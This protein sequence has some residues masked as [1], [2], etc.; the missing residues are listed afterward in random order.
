MPLFQPSRTIYHIG[1]HKTG[2]TSIQN[3]LRERFAPPKKTPK[4]A[5][6]VLYPDVG[7]PKDKAGNINANHNAL[8]YLYRKRNHPAVTEHSAA[9]ITTKIVSS[10]NELQPDTLVFS[11]EDAFFIGDRRPAH[12]ELAY[13]DAIIPYPKEFVALLRRPDLYV[14]SWQKQL[15]WF[16]TK[17]NPLHSSIRIDRLLSTCLLDY[18]LALEP[19]V[20]H[21]EVTVMPYG[22]G[23]DSVSWFFEEVLGVD[24]P[25]AAHSANP[26]IPDVMAELARRFTVQQRR[27]TMPEMGKLIAFGHQEKVDMIGPENRKKIHKQF[28]ETNSWLVNTLGANAGFDDLDEMCEVPNDWLSVDEAIEKYRAAFYEILEIDEPAQFNDKTAE[29]AG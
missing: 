10:V 8:H 12:R 28:Q 25:K 15:L 19:F 18:R 21:G 17:T 2:T 20:E 5:Q 23:G 22:K 9:E 24:A 1:S 11:A 14:S 3:Q 4:T 29:S 27:L 7:H 16:G 26:S 13:L 6:A